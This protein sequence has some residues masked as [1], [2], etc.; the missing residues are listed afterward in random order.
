MIPRLAQLP[1]DQAVPTPRVPVPPAPCFSIAQPAAAPPTRS[2]TPERL[3]PMPIVAVE[4]API[5]VPEPVEFLEAE[6]PL[7][8]DE[9]DTAW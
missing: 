1:P 3:L 2:R 5:M 7:S 8:L 4:G 6:L 9:I